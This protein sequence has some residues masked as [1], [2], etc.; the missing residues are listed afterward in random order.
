MHGGW[1]SVPGAV[2]P[3]K[4]KKRA[5]FTAEH[6]AKISAAQKGKRT[7]NRPVGTYR[8]SSQTR[9]KMRLSHKSGEEHPNWKGDSAV[10][11][12]VHSWIHRNLGKAADRPCSKCGRSGTSRQ[13]NW[14]NLDHKYTRDREKWLPLCVKCHRSYDASV[15]GVH[16]RV[17]FHPTGYWGIHD[18]LERTFGK[19]SRCENKSCVYPRL[20]SKGKL[21]EHASGFEWASID[22]AMV[23]DRSHWAQLCKSCH[24]K[25]DLSRGKG[26]L[27][28]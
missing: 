9:E 6:R 2:N 11:G 28:L 19:A 22:K 4:G 24:R 8:H 3:F 27:D 21:M 25:F 5:P 10:Y 7:N 14:A 18:W 13:I 15:L 26:K 23:R 1:Y 20:N 12:S 16:P 17:W